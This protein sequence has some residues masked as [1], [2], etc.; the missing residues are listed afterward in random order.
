M[1]EPIRFNAGYFSYF[2]HLFYCSLPT[3][4]PPPKSK[5]DP[6]S[7]SGPSPTVRAFI[8][9]ATRI[10]HFFPSLTGFMRITHS[11]VRFL[12]LTR[13]LVLYRCT[14]QQNTKMCATVA[15]SSS[16]ARGSSV[17]PGTAGVYDNQNEKQVCTP[18]FGFLALA[19]V[20]ARVRRT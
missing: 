17:V 4:A 1:A 12:T 18:L 6:G 9:I 13:V 19:C 11:A 8:F 15:G 16:L 10:Q 14:A 20:F 2:F 3:V 7:H 5:S